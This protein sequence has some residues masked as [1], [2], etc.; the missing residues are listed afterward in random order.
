M[1]VKI[2]HK[3]AKELKVGHLTYV[4]DATLGEEINVGCGVVVFVN[5]DGK[6][7]IIRLSATT[8]LLVL[9]RNI[10]GPVEVAKTVR[11]LPGQQLQTIHSRRICAG[12]CESKTSQ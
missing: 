5:Y 1:E 9:A 10:I 2:A 8:A 7:N 6:N 12:N 3:S 4:G 11:L